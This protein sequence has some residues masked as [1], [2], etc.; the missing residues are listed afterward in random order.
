MAGNGR[1][2]ARLLETIPADEW[3][4]LKVLDRLGPKVRLRVCYE[5]VPPVMVWRGSS[6]NRAF[7]AWSLRLRSCPLKRI[8]G[9]RRIVV[10]RSGWLTFC[11]PG[12]WWRSDS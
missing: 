11:A 4:L 6:M 7:A 10:T 9:S 3:V 1:E 8:A 2:P 12:I 5:A